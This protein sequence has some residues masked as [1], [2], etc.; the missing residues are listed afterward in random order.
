MS[1]ELVI[2]CVPD[3]DG[4]SCAATVAEGGGRTSHRVSVSRA[5]LEELAPGMSEPD[6]LVE[7]SFRFLLEREPKESILERFAL[8]D[9]KRYF[10][11]YGREITVRL[12]KFGTHGV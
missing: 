3:N 8:S 6:A 11:E 4:W 12:G 2:S 5:E 9:I 10:P 1:A 7:E